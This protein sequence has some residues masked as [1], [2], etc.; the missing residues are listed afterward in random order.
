MEHW[1]PAR[2][3]RLHGLLELWL[4]F[5]RYSFPL[6][7]AAGEESCR[8]SCELLYFPVASHA[9]YMSKQYITL[10]RNFLMGNFGMEEGFD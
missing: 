10:L 3:D 7:S 6:L 4:C 8:G 5:I 9:N 1:Q 2:G